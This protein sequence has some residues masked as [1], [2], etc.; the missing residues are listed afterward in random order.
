VF[1]FNSINMSWTLFVLIIMTC[2]F[3][4]EGSIQRAA[5]CV[6]QLEHN[7]LQSSFQRSWGRERNSFIANMSQVSNISDAH[8]LYEQLKRF[9]EKLLHAKKSQSWRQWRR[10]YWKIMLDSRLTAVETITRFIIALMY[11]EDNILPESFKRDWTAEK[12]TKWLIDC[13]TLVNPLQKLSFFDD[14]YSKVEL[15]LENFGHKSLQDYD[16]KTSMVIS[17][18]TT[19]AHDIESV[20]HK[21]GT[22]E[23][24]AGVLNISSGILG[25]LGL[26]LAPFTAGTSLVLTGASIAL[27]LKGTIVNHLSSRLISTQDKIRNA[28]EM[29]SAIIGETEA[30]LQVL[31]SYTSSANDVK[32]MLASMKYDHAIEYNVTDVSHKIIRISDVRKAWR[33]QSLIKELS[34]KN[35]LKAAS[36]T[37]AL[38]VAAPGIQIR[39]LPVGPNGVPKILF[40]SATSLSSTAAKLSGLFSTL[41]IGFGIWGTIN[42]VNRIKEAMSVA[43]EFQRLAHD[44]AHAKRTIL[45]SFDIDDEQQFKEDKLWTKYDEHGRKEDW[46]RLFYHGDKFATLVL[47]SYEV[48]AIESEKL[49]RRNGVF[50]L[51][52]RSKHDSDII[53][54]WLH[55]FGRSAWISTASIY[56][57]YAEGYPTQSGPRCVYFSSN[58]E[59]KLVNGHCSKEGKS[60]FLCST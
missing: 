20:G 50:Q 3:R 40:R 58:H 1:F 17:A 31:E 44:L 14:F 32:T 55:E 28:T 39:K 38:K 19:V 26:I 36:N 11:M 59:F 42:G 29:T 25:A 45:M 53:R 4:G 27:G 15:I 54:S 21:R 56:K 41:S 57:E 6:T 16:T 5:E 18:L 43:K 13:K 24:A 47:L 46:Y 52:L 35:V 49:C 37:Q 22:M 12:R 7:V 2:L 34:P 10:N 33:M 30:L 9:E 48:N 8:V 51:S 60:A 23:T